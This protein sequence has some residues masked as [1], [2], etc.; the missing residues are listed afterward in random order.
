MSD[1]E[2]LTGKRKHDSACIRSSIKIRGAMDLFVPIPAKSDALPRNMMSLSQTDLMA[3]LLFRLKST[4]YTHIGLTHIVVGQPR[5]P[6]DRASVAIPDTSSSRLAVNSGVVVLRRLHIVVE[7]LSE[8]AIFSPQSV[9]QEKLLEE[10]DLIS[11]SPRSEVVFQAACACDGIDIVTLD[12]TMS[13]SNTLPYAIRSTDIRSIRSRNG[14]LEVPYAVPILNRS[15]R[16]GLVQTCRSVITASLGGGNDTSS[17]SPKIPVLFSS[18]IRT[19][20]GSNA[21]TRQTDVGSIAL[22]TPDD[23]VNVLQSVLLF[24]SKTA[25]LSVTKSG[26]VALNHG[27]KRRQKHQRHQLG[28]PSLRNLAAVS[29]TKSETGKRKI[30]SVSSRNSATDATSS[31]LTSHTLTSHSPKAIKTSGTDAGCSIDR[32]KKSDDEEGFI[33]F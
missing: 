20:N 10:Y 17:T 24:D 22:R 4:M 19:A 7:S 13:A 31:S 8:M 16:K 30:A 23:L 5:D 14:V 28:T 3:Q 6:E 33:S 1:P 32:I 12:G 21:S 18:G 2:R 26:Q 27:R 9:A 15:A 25:L 11:I 29:E